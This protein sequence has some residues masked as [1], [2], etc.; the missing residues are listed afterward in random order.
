M[1]YTGG[2]FGSIAYP[3]YQSPHGG[4]YKPLDESYI[5][6]QRLLDERIEKERREFEEKRR[7]EQAREF[8]NFWRRFD[9]FFDDRP[10][11]HFEAQDFEYEDV[12]EDY[13]FN[14]FGLKRSA[15]DEDMKKAYHKA[16]RETHPDKTGEDSEDEFREVQEAYEYYTNY[17]N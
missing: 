16:V 12:D 10:P 3:L 13:P 1:F 15:S 14:V 2:T 5:E 9:P 4:V 8:R 11:P 7:K 6:Y 17:M